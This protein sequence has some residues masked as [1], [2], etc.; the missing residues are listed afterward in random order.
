MCKEM[1]KNNKTKKRQVFSKTE[2]PDSNCA[3]NI[4][5]NPIKLAPEN[6][7]ETR[8][9]VSE[10]ATAGHDSGNNDEKRIQQINLTW[11]SKP[12]TTF[13]STFCH[14]CKDSRADVVCP[15]CHL[16]RYCSIEHRKAHWYSHADICRA[17]QQ[18]MAREQ[19][20]HIFNQA[21]GLSAQEFRLF[22][23]NLLVE[24]QNSVER[25][26]QLWE[27]EMF[28]Y[29]AV[30]TFC[31]NPSTKILETCNRCKMAAFC[32]AHKDKSAEHEEWC[33]VLTLLR[34]FAISEWKNGAIQI[35]LPMEMSE[36][37]LRIPETFEN[38]LDSCNITDVFERIQ[39]TQ[40]ITAPLTVLFGADDLFRPPTGSRK[41]FV[42][43]LIG[44]EVEFELEPVQK[45]E[46]F[47]QHLVPELEALKLV[48]IGPELLESQVG[49]KFVGCAECKRR[50]KS[51]DVI[52]ESGLLYHEYI[53][54]E[55]YIKPDLVCIFNPGLSRLT[56]YNEE[57]SWS[58]TIS[59]MFQENVPVVMTEYTEFE[60]T[61][62][63][64]RIQ[65]IASVNI[66]KAPQKNPFSSHRPY[67]NFISDDCIPVIFKNYYICVMIATRAVN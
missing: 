67:R 41:Q 47:F 25:Q 10:D 38:I 34:D 58:D 61:S 44:A 42:V 56:G 54:T 1:G 14:V 66:L 6:Q 22:R 18:L 65:D 43:H 39:L 64:K 19:E 36:K 4:K 52:F 46:L 60:I 33:D 51:L 12:R 30:C 24:C 35:K 17:V 3:Q 62:D 8:E 37:N 28:L 57:D 49:E 5:T 45:W 2:R 32:P 59:V 20:D 29:P 16:I 23:Y 7:L 11:F 63:L 15:K 21:S 40:L 27:R 55:K 13:F 9:V 31:H 26:L 48:L 50:N 53:T